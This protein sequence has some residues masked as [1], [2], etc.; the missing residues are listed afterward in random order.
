MLITDDH[1][2]V[3]N[4]LREILQ[5]DPRI[6]VIHEAADGHELLAMVKV[7][8]Y[9]IILLDISMPGKSGLEI[10]THLSQF[11]PK[12]LVII[13]SNLPENMYA[14]RV[15][16]LGASG[17]IIKSNA[18]EQLPCAIDTVMKGGK[19]FRHV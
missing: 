2:V 3:R 16:S 19:Y 1:A 17:F 7:Q 9:D 12:I 4:G 14:L 6:G 11:Q 15:Q 18:N 8:D 5:E 13:I 10:L